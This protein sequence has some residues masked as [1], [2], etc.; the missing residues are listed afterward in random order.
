MIVATVPNGSGSSLRSSYGLEHAVISLYV[1]EYERHLSGEF[2]SS[3]VLF[4][5]PLL[6]KRC[7]HKRCAEDR[8]CLV[9]TGSSVREG[10]ARTQGS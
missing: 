8:V 9:Y 10:R 3:T 7:G 1:R 6:S 2:S 4:R 5:F